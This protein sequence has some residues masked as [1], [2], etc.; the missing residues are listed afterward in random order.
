MKEKLSGM[1]VVRLPF[2]RVPFSRK[3]L[4]LRGLEHLWTPWVY[5]LG[6]LALPRA[7]VS[8]FYSPPLTLGLTAQAL[9]VFKKTPWIV[10]VQDLFPKNA[11]DLG[12]LKNK[13]LIKFF[14]TLEKWTYKKTSAITVHSIG[15]KDYI[16]KKGVAP[17]KVKVIPNWVD[18]DFIKPGPR[19]N[20]FRAKYKLGKKFIVSFAGVMGY[21]QDM[22][23]ILKT[24]SLL[25]K[26]PEILFLLVGEGPEKENLKCQISNI[27]NI[28]L[29]PIQP[30]ETYPQVLSASDISLVTLKKD[31][32]TPVVPS[33]ILSIMAAQRAIVASLPLEGDAPKLIKKAK[34]GIV[35][36]PENHQKLAQA[37]LRLYKNSQLRKKLGQNGRKYAE[38]NLSRKVTIKKYEKLFDKFVNK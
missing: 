26:Y 35:V 6:A 18:T 29:L 24:A 4:V 25:Q 10:N 21:S 30:R 38:K 17:S 12:L 22:K 19:L 23:V 33:K 16:V 28:K 8:L 2:A 9:K 15:N 20:R 27:K 5:V 7:D 11:I 13:F 37:I 34:C 1:K 36:P 31:V 14:Q 3:F 32:K